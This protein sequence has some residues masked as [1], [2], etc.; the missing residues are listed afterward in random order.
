MSGSASSSAR[1]SAGGMLSIIKGFL[2]AAEGEEVNLVN[3]RSMAKERG[4]SL[5]H[6]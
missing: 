1:H 3:V 5:I 6:I 2:G 4:L